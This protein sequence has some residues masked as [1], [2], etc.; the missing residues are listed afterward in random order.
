MAV[1]KSV[2][3]MPRSRVIG[4]MNRPRFWRSPMA[5]LSTT[6]VPSKTTQTGCSERRPVAA[7]G[8][9]WALTRGAGSGRSSALCAAGPM[10][11]LTVQ[12]PQ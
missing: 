2:T 6:D 5:R 9:G 10:L 12:R 3:V 7:G 8:L 11:R 4:G 1:V